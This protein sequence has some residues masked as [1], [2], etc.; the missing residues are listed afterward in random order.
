M[1]TEKISLEAHSFYALNK[2]LLSICPNQYRI[3]LKRKV[4][5][6]QTDDITLNSVY[7]NEFLV[8]FAKKMQ[9]WVDEEK[10]SPSVILHEFMKLNLG[11]LLYDMEIRSDVEHFI[12]AIM[13]KNYYVK[14][15][16]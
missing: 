8:Y 5:E 3:T 11:D 16:P 2:T 9:K 1:T 14:V 15:I 12:V 6:T 10:K 4:T 7:E 13:L